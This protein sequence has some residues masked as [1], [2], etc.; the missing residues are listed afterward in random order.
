MLTRIEIYRDV[1]Y[2]FEII[3]K[4]YFMC[5][6]FLLISVY[7]LYTCF[8]AILNVSGIKARLISTKFYFMVDTNICVT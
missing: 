3:L 6:I 1:K 4:S 7:V 8:K 5:L 2:I